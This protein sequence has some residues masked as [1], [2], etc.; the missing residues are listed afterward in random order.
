M[1]SIYLKSKDLPDNKKE[2]FIG[3]D[4]TIVIFGRV[5]FQDKALFERIKAAYDFFK[6]TSN[7]NKSI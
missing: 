7:K 5:K 6:K 1:Y 3:K 4:G 2:F